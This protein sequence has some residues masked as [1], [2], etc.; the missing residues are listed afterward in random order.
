[1]SFTDQEIMSSL[2]KRAHPPWMGSHI[3]LS[4]LGADG[5]PAKESA[6]FGDGTRGDEEI[7]RRR[8]GRRDG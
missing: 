4:S 7:E 8:L 5:Q 6:A 3:W 1:M 2:T